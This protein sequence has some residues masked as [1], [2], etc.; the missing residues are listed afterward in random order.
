MEKVKTGEC[1]F[2]DENGLLWLAISYVD[3]DG[4]VS[5]VQVQIESDEQAGQ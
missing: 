1:Y 4:V 3:Q 2:R 5:T